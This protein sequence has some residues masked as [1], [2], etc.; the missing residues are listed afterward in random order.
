MLYS[1][2]KLFSFCKV[3]FVL[4]AEK[5][6]KVF[7]NGSCLIIKELQILLGNLF[8]EHSLHFLPLQVTSENFLNSNSG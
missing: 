5:A 7:L 3:V 8:S 4:P 1:F 2:Q 6:S